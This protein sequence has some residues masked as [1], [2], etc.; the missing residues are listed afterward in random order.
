MAL[1]SNMNLI[2]IV[3]VILIIDVVGGYIIGKKVL[4]P[5][6]YDREMTTGSGEGPDFDKKEGEKSTEAPGLVHQLEPINLNPANSAGEVFSVTMSLVTHDEPLLAELT[7]RDPQ[8]IDIILTYLSA[9]TIA[10]LND[11]AQRDTY[12]KE[13]IEK[14][15]SVLTSGTVT[16]IY[17]TQ[18]II[19]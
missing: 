18:W 14:I 11:V 3:L 4:V 15:N 16:D 5:Y 10:E 7:T 6:S 17:V 19:Q 9:K 13:M 2:I 12:R 1:K 8:I